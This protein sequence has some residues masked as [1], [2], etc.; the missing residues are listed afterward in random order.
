[1][2]LLLLI[3]TLLGMTCLI[4]GGLIPHHQSDS[5]PVSIGNEDRQLNDH[6]GSL[7]V[8]LHHE[9]ENLIQSFG[10]ISMTNDGIQGGKNDDSNGDDGSHT[11]PPI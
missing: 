7:A 9:L 1:M 10:T 4:Y 2:N 11:P 3:M 8:A 6:K 5:S